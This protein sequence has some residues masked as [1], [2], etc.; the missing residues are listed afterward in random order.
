MFAKQ[1]L[2]GLVEQAHESAKSLNDILGK[3]DVSKIN[4]KGEKKIR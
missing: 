2:D 4:D 1:R 3:L